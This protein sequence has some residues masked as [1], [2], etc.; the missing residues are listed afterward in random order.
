MA[1]RILVSVGTHEQPFQR[2]LDAT[3][4][5]VQ[6]ARDVEVVVQYGVGKW[7]AHLEIEA[8]DYFS[9]DDMQL[10]LLKADILVTQASPGNVFGAL[11]AGTWP[12]VLG[13]TRSLREH[14]DDHQVH[15]AKAVEELGLGTNIG[16]IDNL[17]SSISAVLTVDNSTLVERCRSAVSASDAR[18]VQFRDQ[19]WDQ[20]ETMLAGR[21]G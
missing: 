1:S 21:D 19:F 15:F 14:V 20:V 5:F 2:L 18:T 4:E 10:Q 8:V 3:A 17:H 9:H 11:S 16:S 6:A 7:P 12:L 13:R